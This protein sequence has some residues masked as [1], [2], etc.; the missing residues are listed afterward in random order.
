[1]HHKYSCC[2]AI[3]LNLYLI[4]HSNLVVKVRT[5]NNGPSFGEGKWW[6]PCYSIIIQDFLCTALCIRQ[7]LMKINLIRQSDRQSVGKATKSR[8]CSVVLKRKRKTLTLTSTVT[9]TYTTTNL[10]T[11]VPCDHDGRNHGDDENL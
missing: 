2:W 3:Y 7:I 6:L 5:Y 4:Q 10:A 9:C 8:K 11:M 1:M